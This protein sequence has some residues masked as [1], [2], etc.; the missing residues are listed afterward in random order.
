MHDKILSNRTTEYIFATTT[1][2][3]F[4]SAPTYQLVYKFSFLIS[5]YRG[6]HFHTAIFEQT[7]LHYYH[8]LEH[9]ALAD[10]SDKSS[11]ALLTTASNSEDTFLDSNGLP[12]P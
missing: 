10:I 4:K 2:P 9:L 8:N 5:V 1:M 12:E 7:H 11:P 6:V 3:Y